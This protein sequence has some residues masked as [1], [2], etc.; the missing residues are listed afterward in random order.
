MAGGAL[1]CR[2]EFGGGVIGLFVMAKMEIAPITVLFR[3]P[4]AILDHHPQACVVCLE[5][6]RSYFGFAGEVGWVAVLAG[7]NLGELL[8]DLAA[9]SPLAGF[10]EVLKR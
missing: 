1:L 4:A 9:V 7:F 6:G 8:D 2:P 10:L 3:E 5:Y